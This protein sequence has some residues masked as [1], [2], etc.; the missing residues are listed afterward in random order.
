[1]QPLKEYHTPNGVRYEEQG[2]VVEEVY[3][4]ESMPSFGV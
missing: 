1:V 3:G 2:G 4:R